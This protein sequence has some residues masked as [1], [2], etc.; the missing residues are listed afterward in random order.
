MK[1]KLYIFDWVKCAK[2]ISDIRHKE[3]ID[4]VH[5]FT[6]IGVIA[7]KMI[8]YMNN[9]LDFVD[10][11]FATSN[12]PIHIIVYYKKDMTIEDTY[13]CS[14]YYKNLPDNFSYEQSYQDALKIL[15]EEKKTQI[16]QDILFTNCIPISTEGEMN[17]KE[18]DFI[19]MTT[20]FNDLGYARGAKIISTSLE[21]KIAHGVYVDIKIDDVV[22]EKCLIN[23]IDKQNCIDMPSKYTLKF[24]A[25]GKKQNNEEE[26][27][28]MKSLPMI[29]LVCEE[30]ADEKVKIKEIR[31]ML[32]LKELKE[33]GN[34]FYRIYTNG[35]YMYRCD[36]E[37]VIIHPKYSG[38]Y[39]LNANI[40]FT[41]E[42]FNVLIYTMKEIGERFMDIRKKVHEVETK[43]KTFVVQI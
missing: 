15:K 20:C 41:K 1:H 18:S 39:V 2:I 23:Y 22:F 36:D 13:D 11:Y 16:G 12:E 24:C 8:C 5:V 43:N 38:R 31:N 33:L 30:L 3:E 7:N 17:R 35:N 6:K 26:E 21:D 40:L 28:K 29:E 10:A 9:K 42:K 19:N 37:C 27:N 25:W 14:I 32:S 34:E 4:Y